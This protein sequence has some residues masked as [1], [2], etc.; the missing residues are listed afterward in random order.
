[1]VPMHTVYR[2]K[3]ALQ[4]GTE[5]E[6][7]ANVSRM[8]A[9]FR[10]LERLNPGSTARIEWEADGRFKRAFLLLAAVV[11]LAKHCIPVSALDSSFLKCKM[12]NGQVAVWE[13]IDPAL[14]RVPGAVC[15]YAVENLDNY[16]WMLSMCKAHGLSG[17]IGKPRWL[18]LMRGCQGFFV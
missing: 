1:M 17:V 14:H 15:V 2:A 4:S 6:Y 12:Y 7:N 11:E 5:A 18:A 9:F 3:S 13:F 16:R 10:E 8:P